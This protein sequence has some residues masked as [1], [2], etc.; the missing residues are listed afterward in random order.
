[1]IIRIFEFIFSCRGRSFLNYSRLPLQFCL[2]Q[3][4]LVFSSEEKIVG[5]A[6]SLTMFIGNKMKITATVFL[7]CSWVRLSYPCAGCLQSQSNDSFSYS[8]QKVYHNKLVHLLFENR[9]TNF[10]L[11]WA[12]LVLLN[13]SWINYY[14]VQY[15]NYSRCTTHWPRNPIHSI[16][17]RLY[18]LLLIPPSSP[19]IHH[20]PCLSS[21][22][23]LF[24]CCVRYF[25][26]S[27]RMN[28][29]MFQPIMMI[30]L[31]YLVLTSNVFVYSACLYI[32]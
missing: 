22:V 13:F 28:E 20:L 23:S 6:V 31:M 10:A 12:F 4:A 14:Y 19:P 11:K 18:Y 27:V 17:F 7:Q 24:Y 21:A 16:I 8:M 26:Q 15:Y 30:I 5:V 2:H 9:M 3:R 25:K 1:M 32:A 29:M